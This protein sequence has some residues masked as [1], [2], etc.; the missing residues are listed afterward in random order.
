MWSQWVVSEG[1]CHPFPGTPDAYQGEAERDC[2]SHGLLL[3]SPATVYPWVPAKETDRRM[4]VRLPPVHSLPICQVGGEAADQGDGQ[5][6]LLHDSSAKKGVDRP[7][8]P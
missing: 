3:P 1:I 6:E 2:S 4:G 7:G 5:G 8:L